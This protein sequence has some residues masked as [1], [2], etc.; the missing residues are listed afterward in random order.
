M[1]WKET[2]PV[3]ERHHFAQD[4]ASGD[5][6]MTE[7]CA[8]YGSSR[9]T[10]YLWGDRFARHGPRGLLD[11]SRAPRSCPHETPADVVAL[12][13]QEHDRFGWGA[14]KILKRL[15]LRAPKRAWPARST[16][17]D[18]LARHGRVQPRRRRHRW[19]H[20][21]AGP[22]QTTAPNQVWTIDFK[23]QFRMR[24]RAYCYPLTVIDHFSRYLLTCQ[25]LPDVAGAGVKPHLRRLFRTC[26][27]PE[28]LRSDNGAPFASTGIHGLNRLNVWWL[29]LG[30]THQRITPASPQENGA[31]E[32]LHKTLK[33]DATRP[34]AGSR[35][36]QQ[37]RFN[38]FRTTYNELRPHEALDDETPASRWTPS[39]RPYPERITPPAYPGHCEVRRVSSAGTFRLHSGQ[40]FLSQALNDE[41][42]GLEQIGDGLWNI[43]YYDT[44]LGRF[45]DHTH[46]ITG[47]PSLKKKC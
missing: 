29:Q 25:A 14:R 30:I 8:R 2:N 23:G 43:L 24:N 17:C 45:D 22:L 44:L 34:P 3:L 41:Y 42:I 5:W 19:K 37:R 26:G 11:R 38:L 15:R 32:R 46:T 18:I 7:L 35:S 33:A 12:I 31:H 21:G 20:P 28:S 27:L 6:T 36:R 10:G 13:L 9:T 16:I 40:H 4:L 39:P 1:P 47:A